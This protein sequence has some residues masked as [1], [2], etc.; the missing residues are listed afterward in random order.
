MPAVKFMDPELIRQALQGEEDILTPEIKA[1][2]TLYR[3]TRCPV[4]GQS[5]CEKRL[6]A[7]TIVLDENREPVV[8]A[9]PFG[10]GPLPDGYAHCIHCSTDFNPYTGMIFRTE[11]S[12]IRAPG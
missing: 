2:E 5:G 4:C 9:S 10:M 8:V 1:E 12:M 6:R 7:P 3:N 11:A